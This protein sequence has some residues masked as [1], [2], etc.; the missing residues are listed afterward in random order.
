M[1]K[2]MQF[3]NGDNGVEIIENTGEAKAAYHKEWWGDRWKHQVTVKKYE[4]KPK[5]E[6]T[7]SG[8]RIVV[9]YTPQELKRLVEEKA[10]NYIEK[11]AP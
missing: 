1:G 3:I 11:G 2:A 7:V 4:G 5:Y 10:G 8:E 9:E 6:A